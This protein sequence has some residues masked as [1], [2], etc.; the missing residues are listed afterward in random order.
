MKFSRFLNM[1]AALSMVLAALGVSYTPAVAQDDGPVFDRNAL[2]VPGELIVKFG[3]EAGRMDVNASALA[4]AESLGG[5]VVGMSQGSTLLSF[6]ESADVEA[7]A[8]EIANQPGVA[9]VEP[10]YIRWIP[11]AQPQGSAQSSDKVI[12]RSADGKTRE[13]SREQLKAMRTARKVNGRTQAVPT[14]PVE[15]SYYNWGWWASSA[16]IIWT[17]KAV[18]PGVCVVDTGVDGKHPDLTGKIINGYDFVNDD[19][20]PDDDNGHGT[21]VS[22]TIA[23][24]VNN[25]KGFSGI[26][27]GKVVAVKVLSAQGW[28]TSW[29]IAKGIESCADRTDIKIINLSLGGSFASGFEFDAIDYAINWKNKLV[30][31]AA[32][33]EST[34]DYSFPA[35]WAAPYVCKDGTSTY[36][37]DCDPGGANE[38]IIYQGM[39]S[40]GASRSWDSTVNDTNED[41]YLWVDTDGDGLEITDENDPAFFDEHFYTDQ[42]ATDFSNYGAWVN[43]TA[44]GEDILSTLPVS[45][46]FYDEYYY[47]ED[48]DN[49]GYEAYSG[50]SMATPHVAAGAARAWSVF[51]TYTN[52]QIK[53]QLLSTGNPFIGLGMDPN[54]SDPL[55]GYADTGYNGEVPFCWPDSTYGGDL[56]NS[57]LV[58]L[59]VAAAMNRGGIWADVYDAVTGLPLKGATVKA[60]QSNLI[61]DQSVLGVDWSPTADLINLPAGVVTTVKVNKAGNTLGDQIITNVLVSPGFFE[62]GPSLNIGVPPSTRIHVVA[63]WDG[64]YNDLE[65]FTWTAKDTI[66]NVDPGYIIGPWDPGTPDGFYLDEGD[67]LDFPFA[68]WNRDG[69]ATDWLT[70]ESITIAPKPGSTTIP[71]YNLTVNDQYD[72]LLTD[73]WQPGLLNEYVVVRVWA[74]GKII[75][76]SEKLASCD[77]DGVDN[78]FGTPDDEIWWWAGYMKLGVYYPGDNCG[79]G[80]TPSVDPNGVWPYRVYDRSIN[81]GFPEQP[82]KTK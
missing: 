19:T 21:H 68:R 69:G 8:L 24:L 25:K 70:M 82:G 16:N 46:P 27:N 31:V 67:L 41:G 62:W 51:P 59:N 80:A 71:Y 50:T 30:V 20:K 28:G 11:E 22:G 10:N 17:E 7:L 47:N 12:F 64:Y 13:V 35:A 72:F 3:S 73:Y 15:S 57:S 55:D 66:N 65:L 76:T 42:C 77:T 4:V 34:G 78:T 26:S 75:G 2:Y 29:D 63:N 43:I 14:Y 61:K 18:S 60:F 33:N 56:D 37:L 23:A 44:P 54:M 48:F 40:V 6:D 53:D 39:L 5:D 74:A 32:G 38:N 79:A 52:E 9:K 36:P 49:D 1:L 81:S 45:Y 58:T